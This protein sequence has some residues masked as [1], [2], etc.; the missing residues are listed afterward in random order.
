[1]DKMAQAQIESRNRVNS[2]SESD[3]EYPP[4]S[5][6]SLVKCKVPHCLEKPRA[7]LS[8]HR[9]WASVHE[10]I[11]RHF[12]CPFRDQQCTYHSASQFNLTRHVRRIHKEDCNEDEAV[13]LCRKVHLKAGEFPNNNYID[14][15]DTEAPMNLGHF[16]KKEQLD[17]VCLEFCK[18]DLKNLKVTVPLNSQMTV[19]SEVEV[20]TAP[21][22]EEE[23]EDR[24]LGSQSIQEDS[25]MTQTRDDAMVISTRPGTPEATGVVKTAAMSNETPEAICISAVPKEVVCAG[26]TEDALNQAEAWIS[27]ARLLTKREH[28]PMRDEKTKSSRLEEELKRCNEELSE[29]KV[30]M[31]TLEQE[32]E[33]LKARVVAAENKATVVAE[34]ISALNRSLGLP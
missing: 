13:V 2:Y 10:P 32:K 14:P 26:N 21:A 3:E 23:V 17:P 5:Q 8:N 18:A 33:E 28:S 31:R 16:Y 22:S 6:T 9:H 24:D 25:A 30:K 4:P 20:I 34:G 11:V 15:K 1:M 29:Y 27:I 7:V 12:L 19:N